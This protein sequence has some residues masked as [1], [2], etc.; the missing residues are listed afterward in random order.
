[1]QPPS[2]KARAVRTRCGGCEKSAAL[3]DICLTEIIHRLS[4]LTNSRMNAYVGDSS[5]PVDFSFLKHAV[6]LCLH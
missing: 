2:L 6:Y 1:V 5:Y 4:F 3:A